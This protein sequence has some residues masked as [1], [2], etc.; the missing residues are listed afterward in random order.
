M[1]GPHLLVPWECNGCGHNEVGIP[2]KCVVPM[3][4]QVVTVGP[5]SHGNPVILRFCKKCAQ[6]VEVQTATVVIP[7][8][9]DVP[10]QDEVPQEIAQVACTT[11]G[12][13]GWIDSGE[14]QTPRTQCGTCSGTGRVPKGT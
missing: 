9:V 14:S 6:N 13:E 5:K 1:S 12:G 11:C 8:Q 2:G 3:A 10:A 4:G 7:K